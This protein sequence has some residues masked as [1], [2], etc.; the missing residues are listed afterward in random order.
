MSIGIFIDPGKAGGSVA[1]SNSSALPI[2]TH[3]WENETLFIAWIKGL[4]LNDQITRCVIEEVGGFIGKHQPGSR[5]FNFGDNYGFQRGVIMAYGIPLI[6]VKPQEWQKGLPKLKGLTDSRR[7][8]ALKNL[9]VQR[10]PE[11]PLTNYNCDAYL[12]ADW[13]YKTF[14][15]DVEVGL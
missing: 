3:K 8:K 13:Y 9:A 14:G 6:T 15:K 7:K 5:M 1:F 2:S 12:I 10:Y 11:E 4:K